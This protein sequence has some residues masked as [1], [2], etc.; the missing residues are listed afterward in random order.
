MPETK[1][2]NSPAEAS[3]E[4]WERETLEPAL[5]KRPERKGRFETVSLDEVRRLYTPADLAGVD[6]ERDTSYPGEPLPVLTLEFRPVS[7]TPG[8]SLDQVIADTGAD[9][10]AL[11]WADCQHLQLDPAYGRPGW[12]GGVAGSSAATLVFR[13][14]VWLDGQEYPCRLQADFVGN[15]RI[16]GRDVLNQLD[17]LFRGPAGEVVVNP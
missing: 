12:M 3:V 6:Y 11:P 2:I 5:G 4:R 15:E 8:V 14:W 1:E 10:T 17:A 16:L 9:A 7:G 13:A